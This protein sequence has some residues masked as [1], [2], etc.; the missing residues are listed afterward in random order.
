[1]RFLISS[2]TLLSLCSSITAKVTDPKCTAGAQAL[3][4]P[5][6]AYAPAQSFCTKKYPAS[7]TTLTAAPT[8]STS[9][10]T[11]PGA[12]TTTTVTAP[13]VL[14]TATTTVA[15]VTETITVAAARKRAADPKASQWSSLSKAAGAIL[16]TFCSCIESHPVT[17]TTPTV[18]VTTTTTPT[19][20]AT[21]TT[22]PTD[23]TT[24]SV[25]ATE[26]VTTTSQAPA[27]PTPSFCN[28]PNSGSPNTGPSVG[29]KDG[30]YCDNYIGGGGFCNN[31]FTCLAQCSA[32]SDCGTDYR[33]VTNT[34]CNNNGNTCAPVLPCGTAEQAQR[35]L[36]RGLMGLEV[37]M[38]GV[39][40][41]GLEEGENRR[42]GG[43]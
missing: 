12:T 3:L 16:S 33:C 29:C 27:G 41:R 14:T 7:T 23:T 30:C 20:T 13:A 31:G 18:K 15:T 11:A 19:S 42:E 17:T 1:M 25:T 2:V 28:S 43:N 32:D 36:G 38:V 5:L 22:T 10:S 40:K 26:T 39:G 6:S 4:L 8:T 24:T 35:R 21:A 37:E 9:T 34:G